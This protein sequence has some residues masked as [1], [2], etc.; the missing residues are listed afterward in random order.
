METM[1]EDNKAVVCRFNQEVIE[2]GNV[3]SFNAL[4]DESFVNRSAPAGMDNGP[5]GMIYFFNEILRPAMPDV[6]VTI[7]Q[8][9]AEGDLVTTRKS[10]S[11]TQTGA[12][13]GVPATGKAISI[14]VIDIVL[15]KDGKYMEHWGITTLPELL[16]TLAR[17]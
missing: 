12:L 8:Q 10:I 4:M 7:H 11:G 5:Q 15:V 1:I 17:A 16:A 9:V 14:D 2:Q 13:L 6:K 3:D